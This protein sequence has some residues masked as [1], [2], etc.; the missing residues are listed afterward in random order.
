MQG[1]DASP[2]PKQVVRRGASVAEQLWFDRP[3]PTNIGELRTRASRA[4]LGEGGSTAP[5]VMDP[6]AL[7]G[8]YEALANGAGTMVVYEAA[9]TSG[10]SAGVFG[11]YAGTLLPLWS[12]TAEEQQS[13][14]QRDRAF[15]TAAPFVV[16]LGPRTAHIPGVEAYD[17]ARVVPFPHPEWQYRRI[18][19]VSVHLRE[20]VDALVLE[21]SKRHT[22][23]Q[24]ATAAAQAQ[25][26]A[27][28]AAQSKWQAAIADGDAARGEAASLRA[29]LAE[30]QAEVTKLR[31]AGAAM[32]QSGNTALAEARERAAAAENEL[33][34]LR[35]AAAVSV[36]ET[37]GRAAVAPAVAAPPAV[38]TPAPPTTPLASTEGFQLHD[39]VSWGPFLANAV[40]ATILVGELRARLGITADAS[41]ARKREFDQLKGWIDIVVETEDWTSF[42][43]TVAMGNRLV[44]QLRIAALSH[45]GYDASRLQAAIAAAAAPND[46]LAAAVAKLPSPT[47]S[48]QRG[49]SAR[50][51][52]RGGAATNARPD[53]LATTS[54]KT[55][56]GKRPNFYRGG[57]N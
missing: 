34:R 1:N 56:D 43:A 41:A 32:Q 31:S 21:A 6:D 12:L 38:T 35:S 4:T 19:H 23:L 2:P 5:A 49:R 27:A 46:A 24:A 9:K 25:Q 7:R 10:A 13:V 36:G 37:I 26:D 20:A 28:T 29:A 50:R 40:T 22:E 55:E 47:A 17:S 52:G 14:V 15:V 11:K 42:P 39:V 33:A 3:A 16:K 48:A 53:P 45:E 51:R 8:Q 18:V 54:T 44:A 30:A 57:R